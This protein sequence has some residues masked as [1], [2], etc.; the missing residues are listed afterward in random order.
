[1]NK[2]LWACDI[3]K[4]ICIGCSD[5]QINAEI[6]KLRTERNEYLNDATEWELENITL[7]KERDNAFRLGQERMRERAANLA[8][9]GYTNTD[10]MKA[11]S[12]IA[13]EIL[14]LPLE[15]E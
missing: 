14:S 10:L 1:M 3:H 13:K 15:E 8:K 12:Q 4:T 2:P 6:D 5:C 11:P 7:L 9:N